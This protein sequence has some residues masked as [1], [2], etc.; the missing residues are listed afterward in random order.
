MAETPALTS[1]PCSC[2][3]R[4][5][6]FANTFAFQSGAKRRGTVAGRLVVVFQPWAFCW[7]VKAW[8]VVMRV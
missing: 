2:A 7:P 4:K 5:L 3:S 6:Y 8:L 1:K